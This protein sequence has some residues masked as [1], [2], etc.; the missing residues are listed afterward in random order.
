MSANRIPQT[1]HGQ[2]GL[3]FF[4]PWAHAFAVLA[5][6]GCFPVKP[7]V[8]ILEGLEASDGEVAWLLREG[9][10]PTLVGVPSDILVGVSISCLTFVGVPGAFMSSMPSIIDTWVST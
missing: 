7:C 4:A 1:L 10:P 5:F 6:V 3:R 8:D 2:C 9:L